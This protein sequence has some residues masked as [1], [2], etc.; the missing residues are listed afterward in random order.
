MGC[1][2]HLT[3]E[4]KVGSKW[5]A[6]N[7][8]NGGHTGRFEKDDSNWDWASPV[9]RDRN[10][11]RFAALAGVRGDG[12]EARG[13]PDDVSETTR[14]LIDDYGADGHSH[15]WLPMREAVDIFVRTHWRD[16]KRPHL[17]D[18]PASY[19]FEV[20]DDNLDAYRIVFWFDN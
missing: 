16:E 17:L 2:I 12:P 1:D 10:Y 7:T 19:F 11:K 18:Y 8:M 20:D 6:V 4:K 9:A 5:I 13:V 3:V 14:F 15:S